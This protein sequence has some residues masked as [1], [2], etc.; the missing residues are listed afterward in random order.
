MQP[1][2]EPQVERPTASGRRIGE[3]V[4]KEI[5]VDREAMDRDLFAAN[6]GLRDQ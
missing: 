2:S 1:F 4:E 5:V 3:Q 6:G